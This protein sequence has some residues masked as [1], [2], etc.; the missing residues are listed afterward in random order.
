MAASFSLLPLGEGGAQGRMRE[1]DNDAELVHGSNEI[2]VGV[3]LNGW[4]ATYC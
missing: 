4:L 1:R 3:H 2:L